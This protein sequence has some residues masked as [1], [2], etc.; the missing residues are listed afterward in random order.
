MPESEANVLEARA[1]YL[2]FV[3]VG[4]VKLRCT[5]MSQ[6]PTQ[7]VLD[8][9]HIFGYNDEGTGYLTKG[10]SVGTSVGQK[11]IW[12]PSM[13][14]INGSFEY[15]AEEDTVATMYDYIRTGE[16]IDEIH[17]QYNCD[18]G[19]KFTKCRLSQYSFRATA[20]EAVSISVSFTAAKV[21]EDYSS[22]DV[23]DLAKKL[24]T[25]DKVAVSVSYEDMEVKAIKSIDI[26][27]SNEIIP[28]YTIDGSEFSDS[29]F[30]LRDMRL[31][32]QNVSG[33][34]QTYLKP[35][36]QYLDPSSQY[37]VINVVVEDLDISIYSVITPIQISS[38]SGVFSAGIHFTGVGN[39]LYI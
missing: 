27:I 4:S 38:S 36:E 17:F 14:L 21:T 1:G 37:G 39:S 9:P 16:Y 10:E 28:I 26:N 2:G 13:Q 3:S 20:G 8:Y 31:G 7:S 15:M 6:A 25:W 34:I 24:I 32:T 11:M 29:K 33:S 19:V 5:G 22:S 30:G 23:H 12:R 35:K 18:K